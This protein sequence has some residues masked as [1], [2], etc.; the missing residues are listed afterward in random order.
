MK[1]TEAWE[2]KDEIIDK[3]KDKY[4]NSSEFSE[5]I[6]AKTQ[7]NFENVLLRNF[8][9]MIYNNIL[10]EYLPKS[11]PNCIELNCSNCKKLIQLPK[12]PKCIELNC[13]YCFELI[14]LPELEQCKILNCDDSL[15]EKRN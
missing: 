4:I 15:K 9:W 10:E 2:N 5:L 11:L 3:C 1:I 6:N 8:D 12:L 13:S 14:S 7:I